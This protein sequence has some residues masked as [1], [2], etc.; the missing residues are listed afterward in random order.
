VAQDKITEI[1]R[2]EAV[3]LISLLFLAILWIFLFIK[4]AVSFFSLFLAKNLNFF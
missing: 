4:K 2:E 3:N 1:I